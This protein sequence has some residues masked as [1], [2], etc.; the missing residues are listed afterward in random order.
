MTAA[1]VDI[2]L[3]SHFITGWAGACPYALPNLDF[4][5]PRNP[6]APW[7]RLR[8]QEG[9]GGPISLGC[10]PGST[11][12]RNFGHVV[13]YIFVPRDSGRHEVSV[14]LDR[15]EGIFATQQFDGITTGDRIPWSMAEEEE[16]YG[17]GFAWEY[18]YHLTQ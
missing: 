8:I 12:L 18:F 14:L 16:W 4:T 3:K 1:E 5:P 9:L 10:G 13:L 17:E 11:R 15:A 7:V 2:A 6:P